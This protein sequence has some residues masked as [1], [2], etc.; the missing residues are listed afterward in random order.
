MMIMLSNNR[1]KLT[2]T[3]APASRDTEEGHS[4]CAFARQALAAYPGS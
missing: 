3:F 4:A 2:S 1:M